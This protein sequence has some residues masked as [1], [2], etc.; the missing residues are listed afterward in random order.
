MIKI[1]NLISALKTLKTGVELFQNNQNPDIKDML[2]DSCIKRFEYTLETSIKLMRKFLKQVYFSDEK[3]LT[4]NNI[5]RLMQG[6]N[7]ITSW[8]NWKNYYQ[9][10]N[11]TSHEYNIQKSKA[12]LKIIPD[13]IKDTE[14]LVENLNVTLAQNEQNQGN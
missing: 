8:E 5:F 10:R 11:D 3:D 6:Y 14:I 1:D 13:F 2:A 12:L 7:F 4:V 9:K